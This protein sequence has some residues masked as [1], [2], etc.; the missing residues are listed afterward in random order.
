MNMVYYIVKKDGIELKSNTKAGAFEAWDCLGRS[1]VTVEK[2]VI[3][4]DG[5]HV[6]HSGKKM[7]RRMRKDGT[8]V[9][10]AKWDSTMIL[11]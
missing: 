6:I 3:E 9:Y 4:E 2:H 8:M 1:D 10:H 7:T 5:K 11:G